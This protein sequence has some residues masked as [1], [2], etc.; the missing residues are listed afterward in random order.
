MTS[1]SDSAGDQTMR[2]GP[3]DQTTAPGADRQQ[4]PQARI[5]ELERRLDDITRLV[6]DWVWEIDAEL[7]FTDVSERIFEITGRIPHHFIGIDIRRVGNFAGADDNAMEERFRHPFRDQTYRIDADDGTRLSF[8]LSSVPVFDRDSGDF[9]GARGTAED[10]TAR[11][12][13]ESALRESEH[14]LRSIADVTPAFIAYHDTEHRFRFANRH[15]Q[16]IGYEPDELIGKEMAD[17]FDAGMMDRVKPYLARVLNGETVHYENFL[18]DKNGEPI[19]TTVSISPDIDENGKIVGYI[20]LSADITDRMRAE[21]ETE[22][23]RANLEQ[24]QRLAQIGSWER[25]LGNDSFYWSPEMYRIFDYDPGIEQPTQE[26]IANRVHTDDRDRIDKAY[27]SAIEDQADHYAIDFRIVRADGSTRY[28]AGGAE[29]TYG[30]DGTPQRMTGT[31]QDVTAARRVQDALEATK[32]EAENANRAKSEFLS[33][34]SHELRTPM[35]AILGYAQLL[36]QNKKEPVSERQQRQIGQILKSGQHLL[37]LINDILDLSKVE[38]GQVAFKPGEVLGESAVEECLGL[39]AALA[40]KNGIIVTNRLRDRPP[41]PLFADPI[42]LKQA[43]LNLLSNAIKFNR[44]HGRVE[45]SA[46]P[47]SSG[48]IRISVIDTGIGIPEDKAAELFEPFSR[49]DAGQRGIE[50]TG[51]GL[52]ITKQ[53]VERMNGSVGF[54]S[55]PGK[56][57]TFWIDI[58]AAEPGLSEQGSA[59]EYAGKLDL[60]PDHGDGGN[61]IIL[62]IED[63]DSNMQLMKEV[64]GHLP[65]KKLVSAHSAE[66]G[67]EIAR[68]TQPDVIV[69]DVNLPGMSGFD[70][71]RLLREDRRT[72]AIPVIALSAAAMASDLKKGEQAGFFSYMTKPFIVDEIIATIDAAL[73][74]AN[75][76]ET[77]RTAAE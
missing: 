9:I 8:L 62:Y 60:E 55:R 14:F 35:N 44:P 6:S 2:Q 77:P 39:V 75:G 56:G 58:P 37:L 73:A 74:K 1:T 7:R 43:L 30:E 33:S 11:L 29:L 48:Y 24:A 42:R 13:Q 45:V 16:R 59:D 20:V 34:M 72:S 18:D 22:N 3:G 54:S 57:S 61:I 25:D 46:M 65:D 28:I 71:V 38:T 36:L 50:G 17:I 47:L 52:T 63:D 32:L 68:Q 51:I 49:L 23:A 15:F 67:I 21:A 19:F 69:M 5:A 76:G 64:I 31:A 40:E 41:P 4:T 12:S 70:A 26:M 10:V 53:L 66:D 27:Q